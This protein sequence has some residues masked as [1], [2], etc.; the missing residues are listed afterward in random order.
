M[1]FDN[2]SS[3]VRNFDCQNCYS[4]PTSYFVNEEC[5]IEHFMDQVIKV[6]IVIKIIIIQVIIC[7]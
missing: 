6:I 7:K 1:L 2:M 5:S 4:F 3:D